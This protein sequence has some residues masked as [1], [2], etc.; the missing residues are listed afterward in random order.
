M[1]FGEYYKYKGYTEKFNIILINKRLHK[2]QND[3]FVL[4]ILLF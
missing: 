3:K 1:W 4:I 2:I